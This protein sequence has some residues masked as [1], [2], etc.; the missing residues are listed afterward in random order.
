MWIL[1]PVNVKPRRGN[2]YSPVGS[3]QELFSS[4]G[5]NQS[6]EIYSVDFLGKN[7][8]LVGIYKLAT[9]CIEQCVQEMSAPLK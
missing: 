4:G 6:F 1:C 7:E 8:D 2:N 3:S 5:Q 9:C